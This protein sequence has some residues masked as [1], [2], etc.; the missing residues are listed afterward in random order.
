MNYPLPGFYFAVRFASA[1][2][3]GNDAAF[4]D[5]AGLSVGMEPE[6]VTEGGVNTHQHRLPTVAKYTDLVLKRGYMSQGSALFDWCESTL[7]GGLAE[8][9]KTGVL[10][11]Q[12]LN[13]DTRKKGDDILRQWTFYRAWPVKWSL[14]DLNSTKNEVLVEYLTFAYRHFQS[15]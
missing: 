2:K 7:Q 1:S 9:V 6:V 11:L 3:G 10:T 13:P 4:Q 8:P 15:R 14:S 5:A 12:L